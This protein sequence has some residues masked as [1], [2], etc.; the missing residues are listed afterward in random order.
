MFNKTEKK[1][2]VDAITEAELN[3]SGEIRIHI[4][5]K[6]KNN[7][8]D[9][10]VK[11]FEKLGMHKT[12]HRNG[13]LIYIATSNKKLAIIG[14]EGIN[15]VVT[16]NF[17]DEIKDEMISHFKDDNFIVGLSNGIIK[18]GQQLKKHFPYKS[19]DINELTN[20]ISFG[21]E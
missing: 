14:D 7:P 6:C 13:V 20:E 5:K 8:I 18:A 19:D 3:T 4:D 16:E 12:E 21:D 9:K 10:A 15:R 17:W 1:T 11:I 2:I